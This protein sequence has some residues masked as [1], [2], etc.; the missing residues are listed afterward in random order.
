[1]A[2]EKPK[3]QDGK[4]IKDTTTVG[5]T[6]SKTKELIEAARK[7]NEIEQANADAPVGD[8]RPQANFSEEELDQLKA[9]AELMAE[10]KVQAKAG[11]LDGSIDV[12]AMGDVKGDGGDAKDYADDDPAKALGVPVYEHGLNETQNGADRFANTSIDDNRVSKRTQAEIERGRT[13]LSDR[14]EAPSASRRSERST[15][16][17]VVTDANDDPDGEK[18]KAKAE[19]EAKAKEEAE[20]KAE[21]KKN[22]DK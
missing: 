17:T 18:G 22:A 21:A 8:S 6:V 5:G 10:G 13:A 3:T 4:E 12:E 19:A 9:D 16:R 2:T 20:K 15:S 11:T 7:R 14:T 1:M